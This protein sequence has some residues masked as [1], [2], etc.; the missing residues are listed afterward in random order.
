[1]N[2]INFFTLNGVQGIE[3]INVSEQVCDF[4]RFAEEIVRFAEEF[5]RF[6][7]NLFILQKNLFVLQKNLF[8]L[9]KNMEAV[10]VEPD[11]D[12]ETH[13]MFSQNEYCVTDEKD[14]YPV[15]AELFVVKDECEVSSR[16]HHCLF[17]YY[18]ALLSCACCVSLRLVS[19]LFYRDVSI[20]SHVS[21]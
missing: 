1:M 5:V 12:D 4:V 16:I 20:A 11:S 10:K 2:Y 21:N 7:K 19:D 17:H 9:Q 6:Q 13:H 15:R 8:I 14:G 3:Y 18:L